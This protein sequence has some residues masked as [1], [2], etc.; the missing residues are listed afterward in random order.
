MQGRGPKASDRNPTTKCYALEASTLM[1]L[2]WLQH[3]ST[4]PAERPLQVKAAPTTKCSALNLHMQLCCGR[5]GSV[6]EP[7][8]LSAEGE[9]IGRR[10][11]KG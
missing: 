8:K 9:E 2:K 1:N 11:R 5:Q 6:C 3:C 10:S 4:L 7:E